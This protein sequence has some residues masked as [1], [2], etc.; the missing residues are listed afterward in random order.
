MHMQAPKRLTAVS[1]SR[2]CTCGLA[3]GLTRRVSLARARTASREVLRDVSHWLAHAPPRARSYA[4]CL[5]RSRTRCLARGLTPRV[6]LAHA[7]WPRPRTYDACP[8][9]QHE[10]RAHER[11]RSHLVRSKPST[12]PSQ[13]QSRQGRKELR[14]H[15]WPALT[16]PPLPLPLHSAPATAATGVAAVAATVAAADAALLLAL[17]LLLPA[18]PLPLPLPSCSAAPMQRDA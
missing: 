6:S 11:L 18:L 2:S 16:W 12:H 3:R 15:Q 14:V 1:H 8:S 17:P 13:A 7:Q 4:T 10:R 5:T 9:S